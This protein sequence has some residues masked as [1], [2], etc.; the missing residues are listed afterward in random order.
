MTDIVSDPG[1]F[2][3]GATLT[4]NVAFEAPDGSILSPPSATLHVSFVQ[5]KARV[6]A[7]PIPMTRNGDTWTA[8]WDSS[9]AEAGKVYWHIRAGS[10]PKSAGEGAFL[11]TANAANPS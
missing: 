1:P 7:D 6:T 8:R 11:L 3:R 2:I 5:L 10:D 4:F 9:V